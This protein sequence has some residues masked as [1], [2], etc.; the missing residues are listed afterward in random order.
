M[1]FPG[2]QVI[3]GNPSGTSVAAIAAGG[4]A[5]ALPAMAN[6]RGNARRVVDATDLRAITQYC[7]IYAAG[8]KDNLPD[9]LAQLVV[10]NSVT[11]RNGQPGGLPPK[12]LASPL[13]GTKP[14][15]MTPE[16]AQLAKSDPAKFAET[17]AAHCDFIYLGKGTRMTNMPLASQMVLVYGKPGPHS[18]D[19]IN[20]GFY[21]G[22]ISFYRLSGLEEAFSQTNAYRQAQGLP[23]IDVQ[24]IIKKCTAGATAAPAQSPAAPAGRGRP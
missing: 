19:G 5:V 8:N 13:T 23:P 7:A 1:A 22:H 10:D 17:V 3:G 14:L 2:V 11:M 21:D 24:D 12:L 4:M 6:A 9:D 20:V 16:L 15:E 18:P